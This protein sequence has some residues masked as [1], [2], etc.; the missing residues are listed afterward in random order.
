MLL[1]SNK[2]KESYKSWQAQYSTEYKG[3][4]HRNVTDHWKTLYRSISQWRVDE[5]GIMVTYECCE[6]EQQVLEQ[7]NSVLYIPNAIT[8]TD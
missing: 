5:E 6:I 3:D 1:T 2:M 4:R 7:G 8:P